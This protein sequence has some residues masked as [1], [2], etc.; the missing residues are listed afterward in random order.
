MTTIGADEGLRRLLTSSRP[1]VNTGAGSRKK[2]KKKKKRT[3]D[4]VA[5]S[6]GKQES[7]L[8]HTKKD[9]G[10]NCR[11]VNLGGRMARTSSTQNYQEE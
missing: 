1:G 5:G 11:M 4:Q 7:Y 2:K 3:L 6:G 8:N 10:D 9:F